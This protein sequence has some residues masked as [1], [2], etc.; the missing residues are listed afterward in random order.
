MINYLLRKMGFFDLRGL[1]HSL[2]DLKAVRSIILDMPLKDQAKYADKI[3][4]HMC[5]LPKIFENEIAEGLY[6]D[7]FKSPLNATAIGNLAYIAMYHDNVLFRT[8]A[9]EIL[10]QIK[11]T[12]KNNLI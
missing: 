6:S 8:R 11:Q 10:K 9:K 3:L 1:K 7:K 5:S 12:E 4:V 2:D